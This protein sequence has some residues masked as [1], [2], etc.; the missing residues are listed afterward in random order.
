MFALNLTG[1]T[2]EFG[3]VYMSVI[4]VVGLGLIILALF[5]VTLYHK[6]LRNCL[7]REK[8]SSADSA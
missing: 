1:L 5:V 4:V 8:T 7:K 6:L 2:T 3:L